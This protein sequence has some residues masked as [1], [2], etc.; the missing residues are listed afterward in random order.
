IYAFTTVVSLER[1][2]SRIPHNYYF[3][4]EHLV[5]LMH[6][7]RLAPE[8][9]FDC[10]LA[11]HHMNRPM[12]EGLAG[13]EIGGME[14]HLHAVVALRRGVVNVANIAVLQKA[15]K[16][17]RPVVLGLDATRAWTTRA[18]RAHTRRFWAD[19][20]PVALRPSGGGAGSE[21]QAGGG[22]AGATSGATSGALHFGRARVEVALDDTRPEDGP[23]TL[24]LRAKDRISPGRS[25]TVAR[26]DGLGRDHGHRFAADPERTYAFSVA[27]EGGAPLRG[28]R[29]RARHVPRDR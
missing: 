17:A 19:W 4:P 11:E 22:P 21:G 1:E 18:A 2:T 27:R 25:E 6:A 26:R 8:P 16:G 9:V 24:S 20:R 28:L 13:H 7:S 5:D 23:V 3:H 12:P 14:G 15:P 10:R 29:L